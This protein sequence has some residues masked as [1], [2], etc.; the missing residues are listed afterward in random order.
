MHSGGS[1]EDTGV[2]PVTVYLCLGSNIGDRKRLI[3][4]GME[5]L[6]KKGITVTA[7]SALYETEPVDYEEQPWFINCVVGGTTVLQPVPLLAVLKD[8]EARAGRTGNVRFGPRRLDIDILL[9][10]DEVIA[11]GPVIVPHP[12]MNERRFVLMPLT[13]I[14]PDLTDPRDGRR[15]SEI[16]DGLDE[17][18]KVFK[19]T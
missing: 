6:E 2:R 12:R 18:K 9:Y 14:A 13:E 11:D 3:E 15:F 4:W 19:S 16:L 17:G 10:N 1:E 7:R 5:E 8:I